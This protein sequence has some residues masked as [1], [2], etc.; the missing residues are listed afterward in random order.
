[1]SYWLMAKSFGFALAF[2]LAGAIGGGGS[3]GYR[4]A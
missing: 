1:M 4:R 2:V 3:L